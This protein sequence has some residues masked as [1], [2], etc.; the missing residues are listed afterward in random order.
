[1]KVTDLKL[2]HTCRALLKAVMQHIS[3]LVAFSFLARKKK[4]NIYKK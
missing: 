3:V 4:K 2:T 1:M